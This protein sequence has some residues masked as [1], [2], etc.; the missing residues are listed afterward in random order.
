MKGAVAFYR[1]SLKYVLKN[2]N[3]SE[4]LWEHAGWID[5]FERNRAKWSD[6]EHFCMKF[7]TC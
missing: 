7:T 6:V 5:F 4:S 2:M 3:L 1:T